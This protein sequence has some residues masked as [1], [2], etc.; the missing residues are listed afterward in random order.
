M[1]HTSEIAIPVAQP[2]DF[3]LTTQFLAGFSP[4][5]GEVATRDGALSKTWL[6]ERQPVTALV[7]A[8][9]GELVCALSSVK[10]ID[11]EARGAVA[12]RVSFFLGATDELGP[13]HA[14]A[15]RDRAFAPLARR[16][17][18]FHHPKFPTPFEAACWAL[19][20]QRVSLAQARK[21]KS[22]LVARWG[23]APTE[24][25]PEAKTLARAT[26]AELTRALGNERKARAVFAASQAFA[27][28]DE[29]WLQSA[30]IAEVEAWLRRIR[31][32]ATSAPRSS[33]TAAS[34]G[35]S[36]RRSAFR[37]RPSS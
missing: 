30:P 24:A 6:H 27:R 17:R 9:R 7:R 21:M 20:N 22:A 18:G 11:D 34:A 33:F 35:R 19:V 13:F 25:F 16:L 31:A 36:R 3:A 32:S 37:G 26:E 23:D 2:F 12:A 29:A 8:E 14:L 5:M 1:T 4:M 15:Q 10:P 28:V